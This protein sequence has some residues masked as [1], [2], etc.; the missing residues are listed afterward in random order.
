MDGE[1][2]KKK[3]QRRAPRGL[4][5]GGGRAQ[6]GGR[7]EGGRLDRMEEDRKMRPL[8]AS[9]AKQARSHEDDS[10]AAAN[11]CHAHFAPQTRDL[12][13]FT[14]PAFCPDTAPDQAGHRV[15]SFSLALVPAVIRG[16]DQ[17]TPVRPPAPPHTLLLSHANLVLAVSY[18]DVAAKGSRQS[19]Q[20]VSGRGQGAVSAAPFGMPR[21][22]PRRDS[23]ATVC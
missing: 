20:E 23:L 15:L 3:K 7:G 14:V 22:S 21:P 10:P 17:K 16:K 13:F 12:F 8:L 4:L 5:V 9:T 1:K 19:A 2:G 11:C 6:G 18:A